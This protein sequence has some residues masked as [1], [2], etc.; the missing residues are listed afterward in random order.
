MQHAHFWGM[1]E[2]VVNGREASLDF[3]LG[4]ARA[5]MEVCFNRIRPEL[6]MPLENIHFPKAAARGNTL[7]AGSTRAVS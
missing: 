4:F 1:D 2:W 7:K 3:P 6:R 5:D